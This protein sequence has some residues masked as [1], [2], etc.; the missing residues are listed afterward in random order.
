M[1]VQY[2]SLAGNYRVLSDYKGDRRR[3][4][5]CLRNE[6]SY[7]RNGV[8]E[9]L[10]RYNLYTLEIQAPVIFKVIECDNCC[11]QSIVCANREYGYDLND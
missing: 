1:R 3:D 4:I 10:L 6:A 2:N 8:Y 5:G 7:G 9:D 11:F